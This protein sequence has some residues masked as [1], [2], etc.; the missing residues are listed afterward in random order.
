M[1]RRIEP[2]TSAIVV[3]GQRSGGEAGRGDTADRRGD[4]GRRLA[5]L[6]AALPGPESGFLLLAS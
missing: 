1:Y 2:S 5:P 3:V 4:R 6:L